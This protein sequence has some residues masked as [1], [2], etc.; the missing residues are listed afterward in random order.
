MS[1]AVD[2]IHFP[3]PIRELEKKD[4]V[5]LDFKIENVLTILSIEYPPLISKKH[6]INYVD[7]ITIVYS[8]ETEKNEEEPQYPKILFSKNGIS[9]GETEDFMTEYLGTIPFSDCEDI[10]HIGWTF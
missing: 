2:V 8:Y 10:I 3:V 9:L 1:L 5:E 7:H 6:A 4:I